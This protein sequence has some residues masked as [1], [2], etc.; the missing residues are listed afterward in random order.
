MTSKQIAKAE[1]LARVKSQSNM[2]VCMGDVF[3]REEGS[4]VYIVPDPTIKE[5]K[6][7]PTCVVNEG[8]KAFEQIEQCRT[9]EDVKACAFGGK[10]LSV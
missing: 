5:N 8:T 6:G 3:Q 9:R 7:R 10:F 1:E 2:V 4:M